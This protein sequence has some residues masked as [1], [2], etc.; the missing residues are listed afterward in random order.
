[1]LFA[2]LAQ[3]FALFAQVQGPPLGGVRPGS[4]LPD[5]PG[6]DLVQKVCGLNLPRAGDAH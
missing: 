1:M 6:R 3:S 5:G 2:T 4:Q